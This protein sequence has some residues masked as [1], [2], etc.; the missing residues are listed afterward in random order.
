MKKINLLIL[1][2]GKSSEHSVSVWSAN[3]IIKVLSRDKYILHLVY[4]DK[5]GNWFEIPNNFEIKESV[6]KGHL[7]TFN[8]VC[9]FIRD[10]WLI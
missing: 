3:N 7:N 6:I 4:I 2:G 8:R 9:L 5:K 10:R 1:F